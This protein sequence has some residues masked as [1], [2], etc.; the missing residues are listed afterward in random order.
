LTIIEKD[1]P[2]ERER[3]RMTK[4]ILQSAAFGCFVNQITN[5]KATLSHLTLHHNKKTFR[6]VKGTSLERGE[7]TENNL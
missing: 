6:L 4:I 7:L 5:K 2:R 1:K 3:E